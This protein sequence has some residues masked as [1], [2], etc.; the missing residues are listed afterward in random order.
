MTK[1]RPNLPRIAATGTPDSKSASFLE[2][3]SS[4]AAGEFPLK[5]EELVGSDVSPSPIPAALVVTPML[6]SN[7]KR[8]ASGFRNFGLAQRCRLSLT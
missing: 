1:T 4:L 5:R 6:K 7:E 3:Q 2:L 8:T